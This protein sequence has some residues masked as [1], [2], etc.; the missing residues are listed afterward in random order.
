[1]QLTAQQFEQIA[2]LLPRQR[3]NVHLNNLQVLN[4]ILYVAENGCKWRALPKHYGNWHTIYTRM[5]RW[6]GN[7]VL[8]RV[9][10]HLQR[11]PLMRVHIE[12]ICLDSTIVKVHPSATGAPKKTAPKRLDAAVAAGAPKCIWLPRMRAMSSLGA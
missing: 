3:G 4:A 9:F 1:M 2:N 10:E 6:S 5:M 8:D 7:G 12:S 11:S